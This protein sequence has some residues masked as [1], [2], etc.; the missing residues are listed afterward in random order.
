VF[1]V[2]ISSSRNFDEDSADQRPGNGLSQ[3]T[4]AS[5]PDMNQGERKLKPVQDL[6]YHRL[7][8]IPLG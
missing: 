6:L 8:H 1:L 2:I 3:I 7:E 5:L 4:R